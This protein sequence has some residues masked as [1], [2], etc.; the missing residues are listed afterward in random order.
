M[1]YSPYPWYVDPDGNPTLDDKRGNRPLILEMPLEEAV[2]LGIAEKD[3][4]AISPTAVKKAIKA[5]AKAEQ[6]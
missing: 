6:E 2:R 5:A 1:F 4:T 3:G